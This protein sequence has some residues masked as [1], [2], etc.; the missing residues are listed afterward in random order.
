VTNRVTITTNTCGLPRILPHLF[1][2]VSPRSFLVIN[3]YYYAYERGV[4]GSNPVA[5]HA[6]HSRVGMRGGSLSGCH[7]PSAMSRLAYSVTASMIFSACRR[8]LA[9]AT[10]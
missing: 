2:Q 3:A 6:S 1:P 10:S 4:T 9:A 8:L 7:G 5:P